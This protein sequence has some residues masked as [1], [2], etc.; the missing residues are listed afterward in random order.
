M[1]QIVKDLDLV[2]ISLTDEEAVSTI[3]ASVSTLNDGYKPPVY[4]SEEVRTALNELYHGKCGYCESE[5]QPVSTEH[6]EHYRPK[7]RITGI[8]T[9][10][11]YWLG[12]EWTN[13][14]FACPSCNGTKGTKFP[15]GEGSVHLTHPILPDGT[16]DSSSCRIDNQIYSSENPLILNP[17]STTVNINDHLEIDDLGYYQSVN[18]SLL[19]ETTI[20]EV[21]LNRD[22]LI[23]A[24][25]N[26]INELMQSIEKKL[27]SL[28]AE[29]EPLTIYQFQREMFGVFENLISG[30][31]DTHEY[32]M[33]HRMIIEDFEYAILDEFEEPFRSQVRDAFVSFLDS[34]FQD[35]V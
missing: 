3:E 26:V 11:Y 19:G 10:G 23:I 14:F 22:P 33:L 20:E 2:L 29:V 4:G 31:G 17:E 12:Y 35:A 21:G 30:I 34:T 28:H 24:R 27:C 8:R 15:L 18:D 32:T 5:I 13:L 16:F 9:P 7:G 6:I 25:Q 1:R